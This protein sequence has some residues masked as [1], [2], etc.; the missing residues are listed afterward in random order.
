MR[1][2]VLYSSFYAIEVP[3]LFSF[4][5]THS[6]T[7]AHTCACTVFIF[8]GPHGEYPQ[9]ARSPSG[10]LCKTVKFWNFDFLT[11]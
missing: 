4:S 7:R 9:T 6:D 3:L 10:S 8:T 1:V 11:S 5:H 2:G